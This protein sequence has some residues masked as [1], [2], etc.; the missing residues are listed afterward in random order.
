MNFDAIEAGVK[1]ILRCHSKLFDDARDLV[2]CERPWRDEG[3]RP[4]IGHRLS[5]GRDCRRGHG[6]PSFRLQRRMRDASGVKQLQEEATPESMHRI[7]DRLPARHLIVGVNARCERVPHAIWRNRG[8]FGH[9]EGGARAL[10]V[11]NHSRARRD[12]VSARTVAG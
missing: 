9:D 6:E 12:A 8:G 5:L 10:R 11:V 2:N 7:D 3:C 4:R 1:C